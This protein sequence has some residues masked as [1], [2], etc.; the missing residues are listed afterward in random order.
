MTDLP[1]KP[2]LFIDRNSGGRLFREILAKADIKLVLHDEVFR[3]P[4]T[5]DET[6]VKEIGLRRWIAITCDA[7]TMKSPLF[8]SALKRS[9]ARVFILEAMNG[10]SAEGKAKCIIDAYD[11]IVEISRRDPPMFWRFN[12]QGKPTCIDF[13]H[14]LGLLRR[15]GKATGII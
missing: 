12:K 10:A 8:L 13:R 5:T 14:T 11:K 6:W 7:R 4:K 3:D 1:H 2:T 15:S 9:A